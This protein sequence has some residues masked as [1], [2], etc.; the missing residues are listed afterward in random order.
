[1]D[2]GPKGEPGGAESKDILFLFFFFRECES[3]NEIEENENGAL[4]CFS[5]HWCSMSVAFF[6]VAVHRGVVMVIVK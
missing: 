2:E 6:V 4:N 5:L 3:P 1:M